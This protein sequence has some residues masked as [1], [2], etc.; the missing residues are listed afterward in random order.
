[1]SIINEKEI[2]MTQDEIREAVS[3]TRAR[4]LKVNPEDRIKMNCSHRTQAGKLT[5]V[6]KVIK[7]TNGNGGFVDRKVLQCST[8]G[9]II[10]QI[11]E[12]EFKQIMES[13]PAVVTKVINYVKVFDRKWSEDERQ[14]MTLTSFCIMNLL[15]I[16]EATITEA[17]KSKNKDNNQGPRKMVT[18]SSIFGS[19]Y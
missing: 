2:M 18:S 10:E 13:L 6:P 8:C 14:F 5:V 9:S 19:R 17:R 7:V 3:A 15:M 16:F 1:M 12:A 4:V 11:T